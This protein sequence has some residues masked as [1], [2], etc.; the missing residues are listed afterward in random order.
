VA[1]VFAGTLASS[2]LHW[3]DERR[4]T[5]TVKT[6]DGKRVTGQLIE[7][8]VKIA[9]V[10]GRTQVLESLLAGGRDVNQRDADGLTALHFAALAGRVA[11]AAVLLRHDADVNAQVPITATGGGE[12][13]L[14]YAAQHVELSRLLLDA[15]ADASRV[16]KYG[17]GA[18]HAAAACGTTP[19]VR[20]TKRCRCGGSTGCSR[21]EPA[22]ARSTFGTALGRSR[23]ASGMPEP[24]SGRRYRRKASVTSVPLSAMKASS[25]VRVL[26]ATATSGSSV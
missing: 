19:A 3:H 9:I 4:R 16:D 20:A 13:P 1:I 21:S 6:E 26:P 23:N 18:T 25:I 12:T 8:P 7:D 15:G 17:R 22:Q 5:V 24:S 11:E 14:M 2:I 10:D